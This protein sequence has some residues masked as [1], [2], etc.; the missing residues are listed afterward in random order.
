MPSFSLP[1]LSGDFLELAGAFFWAAHLL[2][3]GWLSPRTGATRLA[4]VQF[5]FCSVLSLA[6]AT[7]I[8]TVTAEGLFLALLPILYGGL[9]SVGIAY[10]LQVV[11]QKNA[12]PAHAAIILS[13]ESVFAALGG[14]MLLGETLSMR[15]IAGCVLMLSGMLVSQLQSYIFRPPLR[16]QTY[17][18]PQQ[19]S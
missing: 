7:A 2:I 5:A 10:T 8:E 15:G 16:R 14:W 18:A 19:A 6:V 4:F 13:L 1:E 17:S 12:H 3:V 11:A 9:L